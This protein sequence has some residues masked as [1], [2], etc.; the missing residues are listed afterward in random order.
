MHAELAPRRPHDVAEDA[1]GRPP[2]VLPGV[3]LGVL[4]DELLGQSIDGIAGQSSGGALCRHLRGGRI[5]AVRHLEHRLGGELAGG[6][7]RDPWGER[8]LAPAP[9]GIGEADHVALEPAWL[10]DHPQAAGAGVADLV[11]LGARLEISDRDVGEHPRHGVEFSQRPEN[12][13]T[14]PSPAHSPT[15]RQTDWGY[16]WWASNGCPAGVW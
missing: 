2:G 9:G 4:F 11:A 7:E 15:S 3:A 6:G 5:A 13:R 8:E 1:G 14:T 16:P 12:R 10:H